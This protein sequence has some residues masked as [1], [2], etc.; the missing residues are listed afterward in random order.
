M[1]TERH[2]LDLLHFRYGT[3]SGNGERYVRAEHVRNDAGFAAT[4]TADMMVQD[5]WPSMGLRLHGFEIKCSR[6]DW[7]NEVKDPTK[8]EAFK[9]HTHYWWLAIADKAMVKPGELPAD[10][11]ML[12]IGKGGVLTVSKAAPLL[13][14]TPLTAG[15]SASMLRAT[16]KTAAYLATRSCSEHVWV[17]PDHG[18]RTCIRCHVWERT[19][20]AS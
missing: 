5:L 14:P 17:S 12:T 3:A 1:S 18:R 11:G 10:W 15:F 8:A 20:V 6:S 9:R 4:R 13:T 19:E 2:I 7:L 16:A